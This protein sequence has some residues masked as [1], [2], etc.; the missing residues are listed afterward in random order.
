M[1]HNGRLAPDRNLLSLRLDIEDFLYYEADLIDRREF[2]KW[3]TLLADDLRYRMPIARNLAA[4]EIAN[5]HLSEPLS[6]AWFDE[7][8]ETLAVRIAQ[9][10]TGVH[11]AEEPLSRTSH[12]VTN[13]RVL[14]AKPSVQAA[15]EVEVSCRFLVYRH[16]NSDTEDTLIGRRVDRLR[17]AEGEWSLFERTIFINQTVL[18]ANSLSFFV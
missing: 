5:E 11:W 15:Q 10:K 7:G 8:K 2:D 6:V 1:E 16:R 4:Q 14:S 9:I 17:R 3:L 18:L 13:V 12:V